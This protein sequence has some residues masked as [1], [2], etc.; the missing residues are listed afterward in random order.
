MGGAETVELSGVSHLDKLPQGGARR[1]H[2][3]AVYEY[4]EKLEIITAEA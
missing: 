2:T 3:G 4:G 1:G